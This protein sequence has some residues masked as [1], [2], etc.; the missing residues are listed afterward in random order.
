VSA[1][2]KLSLPIVPPFAPMEAELKREL[3]GDGGWQYEPKWDGFRCLA[4]RDGDVVALAGRPGYGLAMN[5]E[6][7]VSKVKALGLPEGS[8][9]VFGSCPL[10]ALGL[11]EANDIDMVVSPECHAMLRA[12]G[13]QERVKSPSDHPLVHDVFEVHQTW[14]FGVKDQS[15]E[16]LLADAQLVDGVPFASIEAVRTWKTASGRPKDL[17]DI[18]LIDA[19]SWGQ[20]NEH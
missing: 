10:A 6:E 11:R 4:F 13:W 17:Q 12:R 1:W 20:A 2:T 8:Y 18:A 19:Y 16:A 3:P 14:R 7:I 9:I 5:K 15:L